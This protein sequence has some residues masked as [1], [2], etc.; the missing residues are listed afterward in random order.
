M[1]TYMTV[2]TTV[3]G[4]ILAA[5]GAANNNHAMMDVGLTF[6]FAVAG[7]AHQ[8]FPRKAGGQARH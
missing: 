7:L 8:F 3:T 2:L 4:I 5:A 1:P 6:F